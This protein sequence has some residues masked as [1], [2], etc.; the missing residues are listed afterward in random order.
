LKR[1]QQRALR[2][3]GVAANFRQGFAKIGGAEAQLERK[4]DP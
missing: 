2:L 1:A 3:P 4:V